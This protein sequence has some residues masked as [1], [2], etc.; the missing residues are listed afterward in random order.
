MKGKTVDEILAHIIDDVPNEN[1]KSAE[2]SDVEELARA[3]ESDDNPQPEEVDKT[4]SLDEPLTVE[5]ENNPSEPVITERIKKAAVTATIIDT[6]GHVDK[7]R[8][9]V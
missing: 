4:A 9:A 2:L 3:L 8:N 5:E 6:L 7:I 1:E